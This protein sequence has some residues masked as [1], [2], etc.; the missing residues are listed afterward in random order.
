MSASIATKLGQLLLDQLV[1]TRRSGFRE[2]AARAAF[3]ACRRLMLVIADPVVA[4]RLAGTVVQLPLSHDLPVIRSKH[5]E[6]A[7]AIGRIARVVHSRYPRLSL[8]D[9]GANVGDTVAI[10]REHAS[11]PIL[12]IDGDAEFFDLLR[13]N[14]EREANVEAV[15]AIVDDAT[16]ATEGSLVSKQGTARLQRTERTNS[17]R[18]C[19]LV[20]L[21]QEFP[22]FLS[23]KLIKVDTDGMDTRILMGASGLLDSVRPVLFCEYDPH[24]AALAGSDARELL[25][26][27][28][29]S[30]YRMA[31]VYENTGEYVRTLDLTRRDEVEDLH[32]FYSGRGGHRYADLCVFHE[33]DQAL[34]VA[35]RSTELEYFRRTRGVLDQA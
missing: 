33:E 1:G 2:T 7:L 34:W 35:A 32:A 12:C 23:S 26:L 4:Y 27:L 25:G 29:K 8:I 5:P 3:I 20:D 16:R 15:C 10:V 13:S 18:T 28:V 19:S 11:F 21:L 14:I 17:V 31:M 6:Y 22:A 9:I 30:G 24:L